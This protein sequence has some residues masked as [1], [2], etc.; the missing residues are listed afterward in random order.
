MGRK[1]RARQTQGR[2]VRAAEKGQTAKAPKQEAT[3]AKSEPWWVLPDTAHAPSPW[4][5]LYWI[6]IAA[7]LLRAAV[8]L[9]G[10]FV[11]HPDEIMQYL[12]SAHA[13]VF[14]SGITHWEFFFGGRSWFLPGMVASVL[15]LCKLVGLGEPTYYI[16]AV[17]LVFCA[18]SLLIPAAL[19]F[20]G[21]HL[22]GETTGRVALVL[23]AFWYELVGFAHKPMTEFLATGILLVMVAI[24]LRPPSPRRTATVGALAGLVVA[25]RFQYVF[26]AAILPLRDLV[27]GSGRARF[28]TL[29][30]G[31]AVVLLAGFFDY[32]TWGQFFHSY[33]V[34]FRFNMS[35]DSARLN[36]P[37][38]FQYLVQLAVA[39]GGTFLAAVAASADLRKRILPLSL[40]VAVL[41]PHMLQSHHEYRYVFA[42][43]P[44]WLLLFADVLA[45]GWR[46][47]S[48]AGGAADHAK[49]SRR[50]VIGVGYAGLVSVLGILNALPEQNLLGVYTANTQESIK[51]NFIRNQDPVFAT[52]RRLSQ[53]PSVCGIFDSTR[54]YHD[55]P[56]YYYLHKRIPFYT[57]QTAPNFFHIMEAQNYVSHIISDPPITPQGLAQSQAGTVLKISETVGL[58]LPALVNDGTRASL[59]FFD[60]QGN[61]NVLSDFVLLE[62]SGEFSLWESK[63][64]CA[65]R[66]W[67]RYIVSP[68]S[69]ILYQT[70]QNA[71]G[72]D[73]PDPAQDFGIQFA[74]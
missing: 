11:V 18:I 54:P 23:G 16:P 2:R 14:G 7:F 48:S 66:Q 22:F 20:L 64:P 60:S 69:Q 70:V 36:E 19:Y 10:D 51:V 39:S 40:A 4:Q 61:P 44:L 1:R 47:S 72:E 8:A 59:T 29:A 71:L 35:L 50:L 9:A 65:V 53:M 32:L 49:F 58:A 57:S 31:V 38:Q 5:G 45:R 30:S 26:A 37:S 74:D 41:L 52:Y 15:W 25:V 24:A 63:Q 62:E 28:A 73:I 42:V 13:V 21:R 43:V 56:G 12:E 34:N 6:L 67:Q 33:L 46:P 55:S 27:R 3:P 17:K 68:D